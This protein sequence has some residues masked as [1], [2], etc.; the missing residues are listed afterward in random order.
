MVAIKLFRAKF[1]RTIAGSS[2][3]EPI[4]TMMYKNQE[5]WQATFKS[6]EIDVSVAN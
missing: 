5:F 3:C 4:P 1:E 2:Y 6:Y